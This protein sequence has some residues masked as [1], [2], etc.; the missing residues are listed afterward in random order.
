[1]S[2]TKQKA[3]KLI[4]DL[5]SLVGMTPEVINMT[6]ELAQGEYTLED[7]TKFTIDADGNLINVVAPD[8]AIAEAEEAA[9]AEEV[10]VEMAAKKKLTDDLAEAVEAL[11]LSQAKVKDLETEVVTLSKTPKFTGT[12]GSSNKYEPIEITADM[13]YSQKVQARTRNLLNK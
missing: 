4:E 1:M 13:T 7:G 5:T 8:A 12:P 9:K 3:K 10:A 6:S 11:K 2:D